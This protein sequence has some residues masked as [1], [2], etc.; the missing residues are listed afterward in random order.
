MR[1]D[2]RRPFVQVCALYAIILGAAVL[3]GTG[4]LAWAFVASL[5]FAVVAPITCALRDAWWAETTLCAVCLFAT[6]PL[7]SVLEAVGLIRLRE[8]AMGLLGPLLVYA[9]CVPI[10]GLIRYARVRLAGGRT[11]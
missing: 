11:A 3:A 10:S 9:M 8:D 1:F 2:P 6:V 5:L 4:W 7:Y